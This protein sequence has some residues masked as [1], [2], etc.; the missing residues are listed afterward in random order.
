L[1]QFRE[2][3]FVSIKNDPAR[4]LSLSVD[5]ESPSIYTEALIHLV[6]SYPAWP[7]ATPRSEIA[8]GVHRLI[9]AK[10]QHL[11]KL[12]ALVERDLFL[13]SIEGADGKYVTMESDFEAWMPAQMF[14]DWFCREVRAAAFKNSDATNPM[15]IGALYR[16]I[17]K[18]GDAYLP[19]DEVLKTLMLRV[20]N[21]TD[22]WSELADDLKMLKEYA[23]KTVAEITTNKLLLDLE[24]NTIGYL[25][26]V[27]V[28]PAD[29]P[30][31]V[32]GE[33]FA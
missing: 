23:T 9:K 3:L 22:S 33:E 24:A 15:R 16:R 1:S 20:R 19:F 12:S 5:L 2:A 14:R 10:S 31:A 25:T 21:K 17:R 6:G 7:W 4:W 28:T 8:A 27:E 18:G 26:C 13:N 11:I 29:Y 32:M 30:W